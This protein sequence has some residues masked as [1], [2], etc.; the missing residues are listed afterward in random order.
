MGGLSNIIGQRAE[1]DAFDERRATIR[2]IFMAHGFTIKE[3]QTD[4]KPYVY[5]AAEALLRELSPAVTVP[6]GYALV[7]KEPTQE[8]LEAAWQYHCSEAYNTT[9]PD[10]ETDAECYRAMLA[11][12]PQAAADDSSVVR[13][14]VATPVA[15][16]MRE[17]LEMMFGSN[18]S[19]SVCHHEGVDI[20]GRVKGTWSLS[21]ETACR[22]AL[23]A[24]QKGGAA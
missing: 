17:A 7:P 24:A 21:A 20:F 12:A 4:L 15:A 16:Q 9:R 19:H 22:A 11:A 14:S 23:A 6:D 3:G 8:M 2:R 10:A 1:N 13:D 5:E 18:P